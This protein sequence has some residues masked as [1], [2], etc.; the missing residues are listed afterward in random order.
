MGRIY[1][2][3]STDVIFRTQDH[4]E[5]KAH[6]SV[7]ASSSSA[8]RKLFASE[9]KDS[10]EGII[11]IDDFKHES[12]KAFVKAL[13]FGYVENPKNLPDVLRLADRYQAEVLV[14]R[15]CL[16]IQQVLEKKQT[17]I[18]DNIME[19]VYNLPKSKTTQKIRNILIRALTND[20]V[21]KR[22]RARVITNYQLR[23]RKRTTYCSILYKC[24]QYCKY[25]QG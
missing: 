25:P 14:E 6:K 4:L 5:I 10:Q 19:V 2:D 21:R 18:I 9:C 8:F 12:V 3:P 24:W 13:Y 7:I 22:K 1:N 20:Q 11:I 23:K 17:E 16:G 15:L